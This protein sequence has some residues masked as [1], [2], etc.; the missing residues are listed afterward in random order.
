VVRGVLSA[1]PVASPRLRVPR[2]TGNLSQ[3]WRMGCG[4]G[5]R[6]DLHRLKWICWIIGAKEERAADSGQST[7]EKD[8]LRKGH[9]GSR[10]S[11]FMDVLGRTGTYWDVLGRTWYEFLRIMPIGSAPV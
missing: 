2:V 3:L 9:G 11:H 7:V 10:W 1:Q 8:V 4:T 5:A 6:R